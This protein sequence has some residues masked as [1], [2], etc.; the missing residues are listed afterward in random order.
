MPTPL[1]SLLSALTFPKSS[2]LF[3]LC[4]SGT[5]P[6]F[7]NSQPSIPLSHPILVPLRSAERVSAPLG[8][9]PL[10][11]SIPASH[12]FR[13]R[14]FPKTNTLFSNPASATYRSQSYIK[15]HNP[16]SSPS[17]LFL[18]PI[19]HP[20]VGFTAPACLAG[21]PGYPRSMIS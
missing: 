5:N 8:S 10:P 1:H 4:S 20:P 7:F 9:P 14:F 15:N 19:E 2:Y 21:F 17:F 16:Q 3:L 18:R 11:P 6:V 12:S 13:F